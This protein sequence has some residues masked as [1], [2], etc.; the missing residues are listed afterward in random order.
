MIRL[1]FVRLL[2]KKNP[3]KGDNN[4]IHHLLIKIFSPIK[5][6]M[7]ILVFNLFLWSTTL[8]VKQ[9][10]SVIIGVCIYFIFIVSFNLF[11]IKKYD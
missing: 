1:F 8:F 10:V 7:I 5:S 3:L 2:N 4:H 6:F 11:N 9:Y